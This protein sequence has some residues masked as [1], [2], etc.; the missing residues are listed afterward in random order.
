[1][2]E[3]Q[4]GSDEPVSRLE[5]K[6]ILMVY[7]ELKDKVIRKVVGSGYSREDGEDIISETL[8]RLIEASEK[9]TIN[10]PA[11]WAET[12]WRN[13][14]FNLL[15][16]GKRFNMFSF[17][18]TAGVTVEGGEGGVEHAVNEAGENVDDTNSHNRGKKRLKLRDRLDMI[19]V[20]T[21]YRDPS[22]IAEDRDKIQKTDPDWLTHMEEGLDGN[23]G[24]KMEPLLKKRLRYKWDKLCMEG[25]RC[26]H[27]WVLFLVPVFSAGCSIISGSLGVP[28]DAW[29]YIL[30]GS[31]VV[32]SVLVQGE[33]T[34]GILWE[35][36]EEN[37]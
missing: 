33:G 36:G 34:E 16:R 20:V 31:G 17:E 37:S 15:R 27:S 10:N 9:E 22:R 19:R 29:T 1:M 3:T 4:P 11:A 2:P 7:A 6:E 13:L 35:Y 28:L 24:S 5:T 30:E 8:Q 23:R 14:W 21:E 25:H 26:L 32:D 18:G 12:V